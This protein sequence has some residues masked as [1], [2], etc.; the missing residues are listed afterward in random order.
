MNYAIVGTGNTAAFL[1]Q[2]LSAAGH[3]CSGIWG[4]SATKAAELAREAYVPTY[5]DLSE[6]LD[7]VDVCF[8]AVSDDAVAE[9]AS[10]FR[11]SQT[12]LV[13]C[14]GSIDASVLSAGAQEYGV[15][16]PVFSIRKD[17]LPAHNGF[18][19]IW[20]AVGRRAR[21]L[22]ETLADGLGTTPV[23]ATSAQ[24]AVLHLSAV[25]GANFFNHL[26]AICQQM[27][28]TEGFSLS[29]LS[30]ILQQTLEAAGSAQDVR[31]LQTGPARRRDAATMEKH[32]RMLKDQ[33]QWAAV[34]K[35]ISASIQQP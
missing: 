26:L 6:I 28:R 1:L 32:L 31:A 16:W 25:M 34:Y 14:A 18:P 30:P 12:V 33:P 24:R 8:L 29:L 15:L 17:A 5:L 2:R 22:I 19:C 7:G 9:I 11:F 35:A 23:Q 4:R 21:R 10:K 13:H 27:L 20:E 3:T